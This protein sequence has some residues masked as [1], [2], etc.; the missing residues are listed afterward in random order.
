MLQLIEEMSVE[1]SPEEEMMKE[2]VT[3]VQE[4]Q[5][6]KEELS[7]ETLAEGAQSARLQRGERIAV[8]HE[9]TSALIISL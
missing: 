2:E 4:L 6:E 8:A 9:K 5:Y 1:V 7:R 3:A